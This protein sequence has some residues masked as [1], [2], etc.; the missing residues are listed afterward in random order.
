[1][2]DGTMTDTTTPTPPRVLNRPDT[3]P[4]LLQQIYIYLDEIMTRLA[5]LEART[6]SRP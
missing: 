5:A 6:K 1:M 4:E 3:L 2:G